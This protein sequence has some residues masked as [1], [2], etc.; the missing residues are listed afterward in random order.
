[1]ILIVG[2]AGYIGSHTNKIMSQR[3]YE[4]VVFDNL[5]YG[6]REAVK[7][8]KFVFGDL[9]NKAQIRSCLE[10]NRIDAVMHFSAFA[11]VG[12]SVIKPALYY[13][14]NVVNTINLLDVMRQYDVRYFI[15]SSSCATYGMPK[16]IPITEEHPQQPINPYGRTKFMIERILEDYDHAYGIK[17]ISLRYFNAAGADP[18]GEIGERHEPETH[19]IPLTIFAALGKRDSISIYGTDYST[20]DGTCVRDYIHVNDLADAH[21]K[22]LEYL[23]DSGQ[24]AVFNLG[25]D[26][27]YS[28]RKII[29]RVKMVSQ[30]DF[31]VV[32]Q[33]RRPGDPP[34]LVSSSAR[35]ANILGW[36]PQFADIDSIIA[37]AWNWHCQEDNRVAERV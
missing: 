22:A 31:N 12:E 13:Q 7:W 10:E 6:H 27:G 15:F 30:R 16:Q 2:G 37:T 23:R 34:V 33:E 11:Y 32:E 25:N 35:A 3:G 24:S 29:E 14:N 1:M 8:G 20:D 36:R 4:N 17:H 21:I 28:V 19:L 26:N 9:C 18:E 5:V